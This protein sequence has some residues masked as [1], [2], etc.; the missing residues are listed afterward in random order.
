MKNPDIKAANEK[1]KAYI[2]S[3]I[4]AFKL[5]G[6]TAFTPNEKLSIKDATNIF[7]HT[8]FNVLFPEILDKTIKDVQKCGYEIPEIDKEYL[9]NKLTEKKNL[10]KDYLDSIYKKEYAVLYKQII[11]K[12]D[13]YENIANNLKESFNIFLNKYKTRN[14]YIEYLKQISGALAQYIY[15]KYLVP[16]DKG[17]DYET[18]LCLC[19]TF[20]ACMNAATKTQNKENNNGKVINKVFHDL[21]QKQNMLFTNKELGIILDQ[22]WQIVKILGSRESRNNFITT[23]QQ[24]PNL[25]GL[26]A[27]LKLINSDK[28]VSAAI[29]KL[30]DFLCTKYNKIKLVNYL[31]R[32]LDVIRSSNNNLYNNLQSA[33]AILDKNPKWQTKS[34]STAT[35]STWQQ[36]NTSSNVTITSGYIGKNDSSD[37]TIEDN[38]IEDNTVKDNTVK[39]NTDYKL[40]R[41]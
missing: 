25:K 19:N 22:F 30:F 35:S 21:A 24:D 20:I 12:D 10:S 13:S 7:W 26:I 40:K 37:D 38:T 31:N 6:D 36:S 9:E 14:K 41:P 32:N 33:L 4:A 17:V 1:Y 5:E 23:I 28:Q 34:L 18:H 11:K 29:N 2:D 39:G 15:E 3:I 8:L 27:S 16:Y